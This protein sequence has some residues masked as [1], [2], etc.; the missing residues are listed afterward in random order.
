MKK[1][2]LISTAA[3]AALMSLNASAIE[4]MAR[5]I[6]STPVLQQVA[7]PHQVCNNESVVVQSQKSGAGALLG[8][9]AGGAAGNA[10]G[11]GGGRAVATMLGLFGGAILGNNIEG[12]NNQVQ[13][14][15][16]C[17]IQTSYENRTS[18]FN[19]VYEYQNAQYSVQMPQDPGQYV[20]LQVT[21][22][23]GTSSAP[24]TYS[25][26][27]SPVYI[28]PAQPA[29]PVYVQPSVTYIQEA[30]VVYRAPVYYQRPYY[31]SPYYASPVGA[32]VYF[33]SGGG[34]HW[35]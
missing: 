3:I 31:G 9:V 11:N 21:P 7:V 34:H 6:S 29:Q 10:I 16:R 32:T 25:Q 26:P 30:P 5:V 24:Q 13:N 14:V 28:T 27:T 18:H 17:G 35:R 2:F 15:Q 4:I 8:A 19:V 20:R 12:S 1:V 23:G 22:I 33:G